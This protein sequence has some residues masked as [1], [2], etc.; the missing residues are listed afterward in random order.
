M[1]KILKNWIIFLIFSIFT[2][3]GVKA[4]NGIIAE[5]GD[6]L[7]FSKWNELVQYI[8]DHVS[9][10]ISVWGGASLIANTTADW[11]LTLKS[12]VAGN[13]IQITPNSN[14]V[15][16]HSTGWGSMSLTSTGITIPASSCST[17]SLEYN[18]F[19][20]AYATIFTV[21]PWAEITPVGT[22]DI[23]NTSTWDA[24]LINNN[25]TDLLYNNNSQGSANK[26]L[27]A[28]DIWSS[29]SVWMVRVYWWNPATYGFTNAQ[30][31]GS[32]DGTTRTPLVTNIVKTSWA[33]GDFDDY[34]VSGSYRYFR[35]YSV[36]G[37]NA[38]WVVIS[39]IE[40]FSIGSSFSE[41]IHV[42]NRDIQVKNNG[43][44]LEMCNNEGTS[45]DI[46]IHHL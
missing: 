8:D 37:L 13:G 24:S 11:D 18:R 46:E 6:I 34:T 22:L 40:V 14:E 27:P 44:F 7:T 29:Q 10:Y 21:T 30:I 19:L 20:N 33:T 17:T 12:L 43:W 42:F 31:Q 41:Y 1:H 38:T 3:T 32:N 9:E 35:L 5:N 36:S 16:I 25:Y 2:F 23:D 26:S 15:V 28:V 45:L 4:W 39:E